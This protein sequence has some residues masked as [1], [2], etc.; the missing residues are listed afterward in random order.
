MLRTIFCTVAA[1][2]VSVSTLTAA[3]A[4]KKDRP[5]TATVVKVDA[6]NNTL[7]VKMRGKDGKEQERTLE[8]KEGVRL[9]GLEAGTEFK[10]ADLKPGAMIE[11]IEKDG[12][13]T[14]LRQTRGKRPA[15]GK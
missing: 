12:K 15:E 14:E 4:P 1:L 10:L 9:T 11:V 2:A 7:I 5:H 6:D 13:L 8:V 3:D